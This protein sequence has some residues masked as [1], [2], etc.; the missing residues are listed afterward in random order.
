[1]PGYGL[2]DADYARRLRET[3]ADADG[4]IYV[5]GL[6]RLR[7]DN[8]ASPLGL[9]ALSRDTVADFVPIPVLASVGAALCLAAGVVA[10]SPDWER[11]GILR[12][13]TRRSLLELS[14]QDAFRDWLAERA[15]SIER[16]TVLCTVLTA[17]L[18]AGNGQR[19]VLEVWNG[20]EPAPLVPGPATR[21]DVEG[22]IVGDGRQWSGVRC[23]T[24]ALGTVLPLPPAR[25]SYMALLLEPVL[26]RWR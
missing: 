5:L 21:F 22:A 6:T 7:P 9:P 2:I 25:S 26:E 17:G 16:M 14:E 8:D 19:L 12:F 24:I 3:A 1:V 4:A 20:S 11:A 18:P 15:Q 23:A 13:P 10:S